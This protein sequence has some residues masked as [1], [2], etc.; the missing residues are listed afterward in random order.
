MPVG[1][2]IAGASAVSAVA[3]SSAA[4]K[5]AK[6]AQNIANQNQQQI[7]KTQAAN[8]ALFK[9]FVD[10]GNVA[11]ET[12]HSFLGLGTSTAQDRAFENYKNSTGYQFQIQSG[13]DAINQNAATKGLLKSGSNLKGLTKYGQNVASGFT[14][15]Y[16]NDLQT[17]Q[18]AGLNAAGANASSN[19]NVLSQTV[20][21]N[22]NAGNATIQ[23][24]TDSTNALQNLLGNVVSAYAYGSPGRGGSSYGATPNYLA[25]SNGSAAAFAPNPTPYG[26]P[27]NNPWLMY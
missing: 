9:P 22:N 26:K 17:Q 18:T 4:K 2:V 12:L 25:R 20:A 3:T 1:A 21:N 23:S 10:R 5:N 16:L 14:R 6:T 27:S 19:G 11:G 15:N 8:D 7:D 24:N 13:A